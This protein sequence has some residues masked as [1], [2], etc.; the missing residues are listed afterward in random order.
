[1][2]GR[3]AVV[4]KV[5][6][7]SNDQRP[8]FN[9]Q[10]SEQ[11]VRAMVDKNLPVTY[12]LYPDERHG[13]GR[14]ENTIS[15]FAVTEA[16]LAQCLGAGTSPLEAILK[17][18]PSPSPSAR[19]TSRAWWK[20]SSSAGGCTGPFHPEELRG[21]SFMVSLPNH[22]RTCGSQRESKDPGKPWETLLL[23]S[24]PCHNQKSWQPADDR[25]PVHGL[26]Q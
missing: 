9:Q 20:P 1:M 23:I 21:R 3:K 2:R 7:F 8:R 14:P 18:R 19:N 6:L 10:E 16:F 26:A 12:L 15:F 24:L 22:E 4:T 13:F 17:F 11:I 25:T 5:N